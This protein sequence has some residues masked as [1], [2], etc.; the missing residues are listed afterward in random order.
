MLK[1]ENKANINNNYVFNHD[2]SGEQLKV[3][4]E[5]NETEE[6]GNEELG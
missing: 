3:T 6:E 2:I 5:K 4:Q 1:E